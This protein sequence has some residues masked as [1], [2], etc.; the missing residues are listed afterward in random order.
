MDQ[1]FQQWVGQH[2][3]AL[4]GS[5]LGTYWRYRIGDY[6]LVYEIHGGILRVLLVSGPLQDV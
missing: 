2:R 4:V 6:R 1:P 5:E 3:E